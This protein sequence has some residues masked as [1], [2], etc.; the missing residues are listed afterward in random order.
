MKL[1]TLFDVDNTLLN[2]DQVTADLKL[3][4]REAVGPACEAEYW[5]FFEDLRKERGYADY[6]GALQRFRD[7]NPRDPD[8]YRIS[9]YLLNYPFQDRIYPGARDAIRYAR[10]FGET[11]ILSDGDVVFQPW[12]II[13]SG[14][15]DAVDKVLIYI[16]KE[17]ELKTVHEEYKADRYVMVDDKIRILHMMKQVWGERLR[18]VFVRQGHYA[19]DAE[20]VAQYPK[21][22]VTIES[23]GDLANVDLAA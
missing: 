13:R 9:S 18:T 1:V 3:H 17:Q 20:L 23:I 11:G 16:H 2:N 21:A 22:D 6:L 10:R 15:F 5:M 8:F 12:K 4:L 19:L 7:E 14:L